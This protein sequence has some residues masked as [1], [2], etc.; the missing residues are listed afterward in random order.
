MYV[1]CKKCGTIR[2]T[3]LAKE[4]PVCFLGDPRKTKKEPE[5]RVLP[6][7]PNLPPTPKEYLKQFG[8][9]KGRKPEIVLTKKLIV[10]TLKDHYKLSF[11]HIARLMGYKDHHSVCVWHYWH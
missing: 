8:K 5:A 11:P 3:E 4:C 10:R 9:L 1:T 6:K 7:N 2:N